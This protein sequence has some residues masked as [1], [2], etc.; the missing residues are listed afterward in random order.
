MGSEGQKP[1]DKDETSLGWYE[2]TC[3][4]WSNSAR[5]LPFCSQN[6]QNTLRALLKRNSEQIKTGPGVN[7]CLF[8]Q[9]TK[10]PE[11]LQ[12]ESAT[13]GMCAGGEEEGG[14]T[15]SRLQEIWEGGMSRGILCR[16]LGH[17]LPWIGDTGAVGVPSAAPGSGGTGLLFCLVPRSPAHSADTEV[18][19]GRDLTIDV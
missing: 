5:Q 6:K 4:W 1:V 19:E 18:T 11:T 15:C 2:N 16:T 10:K 12:R 7:V 3:H 17:P 8:K 9:S 13:M 14:S